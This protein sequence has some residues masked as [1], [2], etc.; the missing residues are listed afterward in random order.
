MHLYRSS[1]PYTRGGQVV[2]LRTGLVF[3]E[4]HTHTPVAG[5]LAGQVVRLRTGLVFAE[6]HTNPD[7]LNHAIELY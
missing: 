6:A 3:A 7:D 2:R 5:W 1:G 4:A